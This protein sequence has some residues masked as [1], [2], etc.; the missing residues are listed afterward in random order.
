L[1]S[2]IDVYDGNTKIGTGTASPFNIAWDTTAVANGAHTLTAVAT[3]AA[4]G[5]SV[6]AAVTVD[7]SNDFSLGTDVPGAT[8]TAGSSPARLLIRTGALG[9]TERITLSIDGAPAGVTPTLNVDLLEPGQMAVLTLVASPAAAAGTTTVTITGATA[10]ATHQATVAL[11]VLTPPSAT[12][13]APADQARV[14]GVVQIG[15]DASVS[16]GTSLASLEIDVDGSAVATPSGSTP[17]IVAWNSTS[18]RNGTHVLTAVARDAAGNVATSAPVSVQVVNG[19]TVAITSPANGATVT[20][21]IVVMATASGGGGTLTRIDVFVDG[22]KVGS[23]P[24]SPAAVTWRT[25]TVSNGPHTLTA[26]AILDDGSQW[27]SAPVTVQVANP[28]ATG[29]HGGCGS[30]G[31]ADLFALGSLLCWLGARRLRLRSAL[32]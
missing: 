26:T 29:S 12:I 16:P 1:L 20:Q 14:S 22:E 7:V 24:F 3:D 9:G 21:G 31:S 4:G 32:K 2:L 23:G 19:P 10:S 11:T 28:G 15:A 18:V 25:S 17:A 8:V 27:T 30:T 5:Q 6:S 13:T